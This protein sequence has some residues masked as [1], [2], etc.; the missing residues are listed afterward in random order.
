M[1]ELKIRKY[2]Q[3]D[4]PRVLGL[5]RLNTPTFF[6]PEEA[7]ALSHYLDKEIDAYFVV[8]QKDQILASGG[9][10]WFPETGKARLSWD[11]VHPGF[12]GLGIGRLLTQFRMER[13]REGLPAKYLQVRT[14]QH[15]YRFYEKM[16]FYTQRIVPGFWA[17][18]FDLYDMRSDL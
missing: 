4:K 11:L 9:Y 18:G 7:S 1:K 16:G 3:E 6:H 14:T 15:T 8:E 5:I 17:D 10:N 12:H 13:I 2:I